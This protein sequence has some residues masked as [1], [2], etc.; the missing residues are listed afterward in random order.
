M[1]TSDINAREPDPRPGRVAL[2]NPVVVVAAV[3]L[4]MSIGIA[5]MIALSSSSLPDPIASH[6]D[7]TGR[8][9]GK[10]SIAAITILTGWLPIVIG[11]ATAATLATT[12]R[13]ESARF[14]PVLAVFLASMLALIGIVT[15]AVND[16]AST[17]QEAESIGGAQLLLVIAVPLVAMGL[18]ARILVKV[19]LEPPHSGRVLPS[20][21][22]VPGQHATW[23]VSVSTRWLRA[24]ALCFVVFGAWLQWVLTG[25]VGF[26]LVVIALPI[27]VLAS[28]R[29]TVDAR[30]LRIG[31]GPFGTPTLRFP[32]EEI[33]AAEAIDLRPSEWGGWG[34]RGSVKLIRRAAL[35]SRAG[36][37]IR[38]ELTEARQFAVTCDDAV[39]GAGVLNDLIAARA[40][41]S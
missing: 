36:E 3:A 16:G 5:A 6:F 33:L 7:V 37:A 38:L 12:R 28:Y 10:M 19:V 9:D 30:G 14:A 22:L 1:N 26:V 13:V 25:P 39:L 41:A 11:V 31:L 4:P 24:I 40:T 35:V 20:A 18:V 23:T 21:G 17:W 15:A 2:R 32:I 29:V 34:Y 8:P 27:L